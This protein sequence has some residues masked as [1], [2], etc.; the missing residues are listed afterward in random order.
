MAR[1]GGNPDLKGNSNSGR[2]PLYEEH[3]KSKAVNL[4]WEKVRKKV[5]LG[6]ELSEFEQKLC[7]TVLPK[8][9]KTEVKHDGEVKVTPIYGN[10]AK[11]TVPRHSSNQTDI[12]SEEED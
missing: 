12:Q 10:Q 7:M 11:Q 8:T 9:I 3:N 1:P 4:L 6:E 5:E 2:K